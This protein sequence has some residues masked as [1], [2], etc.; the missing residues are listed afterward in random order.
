[1]LQVGKKKIQNLR[2]PASPVV[3]FQL[4]PLAAL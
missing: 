1:M 2:Y 3:F 4:T